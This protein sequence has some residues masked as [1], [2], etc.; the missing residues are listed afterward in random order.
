MWKTKYGGHLI[1]DT[2][3][4][5]DSCRKLFFFPV[6]EEANFNFEG[7]GTGTRMCYDWYGWKGLGPP[8]IH[9]MFTLPLIQH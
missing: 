3:V 4:S 9:Y 2:S 1:I 8:D 7:T 5:E 6:K